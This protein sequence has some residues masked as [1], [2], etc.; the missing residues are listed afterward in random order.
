MPN[1][2]PTLPLKFA[3]GTGLILLAA[4]S[5][6]RFGQDK[7]WVILGGRPLV[8]WSLKTLLDLQPEALVIVGQGDLARFKALDPR[9]HSVVAGGSTRRES[10]LAGLAALTSDLDHILIHDAARPGLA[11]ETALAVRD[12]LEGAEAA[13]PVLRV[14]DTIKQVDTHGGMPTT[15]NR[16]LLR[17]AQTP[18][19]FRR[20][21]L[22]EALGAG[23]TQDTDEIQAVEALGHAPALI[24][25][26]LENTK[27]TQPQ[28]LAMVS[29]L[30]SPDPIFVTGQGFDVHRFCTPEEA[31]GRPLLLGG[32]EIPGATPLAGHSDADVLLHT[33]CD[34]IYG[35]LGDGDIG[36]HFPP[37]DLTWKDQD[38]THFL[39]HAMEL[40]QSRQG[41]LVHMDLTLICETP[42]LRPHEDAMKARL[43]ALTGLPLHRIGLK[44]TTTEQLGFTGRKE[45]IAAQAVVT[46]R[47]PA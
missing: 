47:L 43:S 2:D 35:A 14:S 21:V 38:S 3:P 37:S 34:A 44:A 24:P 42:K 5:G 8:A 9:I 40:I 25:G 28:D 6:T 12:A 26:T 27:I 18:Q 39:E 16:S 30:L 1:P 15:L 20:R 17:A 36:K 46:L 41:E 23:G 45:G 33:L 22:E 19:G 7:M 13:L 4:G 31:V 10:V 11:A 29:A 32:L